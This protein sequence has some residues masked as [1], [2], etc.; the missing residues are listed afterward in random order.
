M[1]FTVEYNFCDLDVSLF[2]NSFAGIFYDVFK[3]PSYWEENTNSLDSWINFLTNFELAISPVLCFSFEE[4]STKMLHWIWILQ[5]WL[6]CTNQH[7]AAFTKH[8]TITQE[9][10]DALLASIAFLLTFPFSTA[11]SGFAKYL[12]K[13]S[14]LT[15]SSET[16]S[17]ACESIS[18]AGSFFC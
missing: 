18:L 8:C 10:S 4:N 12:L 14:Y 9:D 17:N 15:T 13:D 6:G 11:N 16:S 1:I 5:A 3:L 2:R 7:Q